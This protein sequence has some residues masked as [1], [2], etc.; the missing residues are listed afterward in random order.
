MDAFQTK[1]QIQ[2]TVFENEPMARLAEQRLRLESI[3]CLVRCLGAGPGGLGVADNLPHALYVNSRDEMGAR[4]VL[5]LAP[6]EIA[7]REGRISRP[8][9]G[10]S[11]VVV[12]VLIITA[13]ALLFGVAEMLITGLVR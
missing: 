13:A 7:E 9:Y 10:L 8:K 11:M 12:I 5:E 2:I 3:P 4:L 6:G 1:R